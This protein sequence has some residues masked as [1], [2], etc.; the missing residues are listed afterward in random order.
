MSQIQLTRHAKEQAQMR[1]IFEDEIVQ[2]LNSGAQIVRNPRD[3]TL[4][5]TYGKLGRQFLLVS[6]REYP[7]SILIITCTFARLEQ[8][9]LEGFNVG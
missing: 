6:F 7:H 5:E 1:G 2:V 8:L 3:G 9:R 4:L